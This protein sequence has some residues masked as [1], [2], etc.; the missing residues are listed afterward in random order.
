MHSR[1][2]P[3][4]I[5]SSKSVLSNQLS[6]MFADCVSFVS[7]RRPR[8]RYSSRSH[9]VMQWEEKKALKWKSNYNYL[10]NYFFDHHKCELRS[11]IHTAVY[12]NNCFWG[13]EK[14]DKSSWVASSVTRS[15]NLLDFGQLLMLLVTL[16]LPKSLTFLRNFVKVSKSIIF[17]VKSF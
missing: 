2:C 7:A 9:Y 8:H 3:K 10:R 12:R 4:R 5:F 17:L 16:N 1:W 15:D 11:T 6:L 13:C 14:S